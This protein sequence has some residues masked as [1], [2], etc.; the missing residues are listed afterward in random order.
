MLSYLRLGWVLNFNYFRIGSLEIIAYVL[1]CRIGSLE[2]NHVAV[3][4]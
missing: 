1:N 4:S 2:N 3:L